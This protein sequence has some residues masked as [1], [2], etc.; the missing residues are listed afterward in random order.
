M[1]ESWKRTLERSSKCR[2][3]S[4]RNE[5]A[6]WKFRTSILS[7]IKK[8][9]EEIVLAETLAVGVHGTGEIPVAG[10]DLVRKERND[11]SLADLWGQDQDVTHE[12]VRIE[13]FT[14]LQ[15]GY[16]RERV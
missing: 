4:K 7:L 1:G 15:R 3:A 6:S 14:V 2:A 16:I 9:G 8:S 5:E 13:R 12:I 11:T 10:K